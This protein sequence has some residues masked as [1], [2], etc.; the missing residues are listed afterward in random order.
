M[1]TSAGAGTRPPERPRA[2]RA[3]GRSVGLLSSSSFVVGVRGRRESAARHHRWPSSRPRSARGAN[4]QRHVVRLG[5]DRDCVGSYEQAAARDSGSVRF[6]ARRGTGE[7]KPRGPGPGSVCSGQADRAP[8][9][10][11]RRSPVVGIGALRI[12]PVRRCGP[13]RPDPACCLVPVISAKRKWTLQRSGRSRVVGSFA[14]S[15]MI[16]AHS[17]TRYFSSRPPVSVRSTAA[18]R[19][20]SLWWPGSILPGLYRSCSERLR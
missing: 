18:P 10:I 15:G 2:G 11:D 8:D 16:G 20:P 17:S 12:R 14:G 1:L 4:E 3:C 6:A 13:A 5:S 9:R 7:G 19:G